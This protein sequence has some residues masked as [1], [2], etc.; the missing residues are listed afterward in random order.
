MMSYKA[1]IKSN[2]FYFGKYIS[3]PCYGITCTKAFSKPFHYEITGN[4]KELKIIEV[5]RHTLCDDI[6]K[7][8]DEAIDYLTTFYNQHQ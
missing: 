7:Y 1:L 6:E 4:N 2:A 8:M 3:I 5:A